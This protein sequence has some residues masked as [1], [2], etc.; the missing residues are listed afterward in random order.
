VSQLRT[1]LMVLAL[2]C[3][4]LSC[5]QQARKQEPPESALEWDGECEKFATDFLQRLE[6]NYNRQGIVSHARY[7]FKTMAPL[8]KGE[9]LSLHEREVLAALCLMS[10]IEFNQSQ[11][12]YDGLLTEK[13]KVSLNQSYI[14]D[15]AALGP[16]AENVCLR[17]IREIAPLRPGQYQQKFP[18]VYTGYY[19]IFVLQN[20]K[21]RTAVPILMD[22]AASDLALR[23]PATR[24]LG[25]IGDP[26][27]IPLLRKLDRD[28]E[29]IIRRTAREAIRRIEQMPTTIARKDN[30]V[31]SP[32]VE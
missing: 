22:I 15:I 29:E 26:Q 5:T 2:L 25:L 9:E 13:Q 14:N 18:Y 16:S 3:I 1:F 20:M 23:G 30:V 4:A 27:A 10:G 12:E 7:C 6:P 24:A 8:F 21:S 19:A 31:T 28:R 11:L 17:L 32:T